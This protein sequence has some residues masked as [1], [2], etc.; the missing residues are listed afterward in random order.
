MVSGNPPGPGGPFE[1]GRALL[2]QKGPKGPEGAFCMAQKALRA[3][4]DLC[5]HSVTCEVQKAPL[6]GLWEAPAPCV[7]FHTGNQGDTS[8]GD[9]LHACVMTSAP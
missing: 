6:R 7:P 9:A 5:T 4:G 3:I 2:A 1:P 8:P